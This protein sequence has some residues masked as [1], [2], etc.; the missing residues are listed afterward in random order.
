[1]RPTIPKQS[2]ETIN[3]PVSD[4]F[5][6]SL[7]LQQVSRERQQAAVTTIFEMGDRENPACYW[8]VV[9]LP[10]H[11]VVMKLLMNGE[12]SKYMNRNNTMHED[13]H[14]LKKQVICI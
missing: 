4:L 5:K 1:M 14:R 11:W 3:I 9:L 7:D 13:Q 12:M 10:I 2:A 8:S 6:S